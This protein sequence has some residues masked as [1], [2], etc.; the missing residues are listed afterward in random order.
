[1]GARG[2]GMRGVEVGRV[3]T[4]AVMAELARTWPAIRTAQQREQHAHRTSRAHRE[5]EGD[6]RTGWVLGEGVAAV[7]SERPGEV[8]ECEVARLVEVGDLEAG[9]LHPPGQA[10][11]LL[12]DRADTDRL[13]GQQSHAHD[14]RVVAPVVLEVALGDVA[15]DLLGTATDHLLAPDVQSTHHTLPSG[16]SGLE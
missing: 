14:R 8:G 9:P 12:A 11:P 10:A 1:M 13:V 15:P 16:Y 3:R 6:P 5:A 4:A 2:V 7:E